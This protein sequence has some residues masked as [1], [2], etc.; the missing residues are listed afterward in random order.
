M[1]ENILRAQTKRGTISEFAAEMPTAKKPNLS[2]CPSDDPTGGDS[3]SK[4][5]SGDAY[6][7][8]D[9]EVVERIQYMM[10]QIGDNEGLKQVL[11]VKYGEGTEKYNRRFGEIMKNYRYT[12]K[13]WLAL[14]GLTGRVHV[15]AVLDSR[16]HLLYL[17]TR[18]LPDN[19]LFT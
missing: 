9:D 8:S 14:P 7:P 19:P 2:P 17:I 4:E 12:E 3:K 6:D 1:D 13:A 15:K 11:A 5:T 16:G 18:F 10:K